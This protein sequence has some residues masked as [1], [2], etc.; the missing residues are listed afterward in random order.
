MSDLYLRRHPTNAVLLLRPNADGT[1]DS[2]KRPQVERK[3]KNTLR[4]GP[5]GWVLY[6]TSGQSGTVQ[7]R[8][9]D[10]VSQER[11]RPPLGAW[12]RQS[13]GKEG[14]EEC[15][16]TDVEPTY[17]K[18][19]DPNML[20]APFIDI[21]VADGGD[22]VRI[23]AALKRTPATDAAF[24]ALLHKFK[25]VVLALVQRPR[26]I[27]M[28]QLSLQDC[29]VPSMR[30]VKQFMSFV[31]EMTWAN[32]MVV[33][34]CAVIL[35]PQG[36]SGYALQNIVKMVLRLLP[37]PWQTRILP[38]VA[39]GRAFLDQIT[40]EEAQLLAR[41]SSPNGT[42]RSVQTEKGEA[43]NGGTPST[44]EEERS[45]LSV[46]D[47]AC[48]D[49]EKSIVELEEEKEATLSIEHRR[50]YCSKTSCQSLGPDVVDAELRESASIVEPQGCWGSGWFLTWACQKPLTT[51]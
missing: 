36:Y 26:T 11:S 12:Y 21:S 44:M 9:A 37:P 14:R 33:R 18:F 4:Y 47:V 17:V 49:P 23:E 1:W 5:D 25:E 41:C 42:P 46:D 43:C 45:L 22:V 31:S 27:L 30:H 29:A 19:E 16:L 2:C 32:A 50:S 34:G 35:K 39:E 13:S 3:K 24:E 10:G 48:I 15:T 38:T 28:L 40:V 51:A 6:D 20:Q 8:P 7:Y